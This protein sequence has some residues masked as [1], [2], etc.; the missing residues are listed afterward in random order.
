MPVG[1]QSVQ[2]ALYIL[3]RLSSLKDGATASELAREIG[4][5]RSTVFR[6]M[7]TLIEKG[8]VRQSVRTKR[9][10]LTMKVFTLGSKLLAQMDIRN[11]ARGVL[12]QLQKETGHTIHLGIRDNYEVVYIDKIMGSGPIQ[13][14][15]SIGKRAPLYC[16]GLGKAILAFFKERELEDYIQTVKFKKYTPN[17]ITDPKD[18]LIELENIRNKGY[19][20]D[21][22]EHENGIRCV[23]APIFDHNDE[24]IGSISVAAISVFLGNKDI[25]E[26]APLV[27]SA[28]KTISK[29]IGAD[30]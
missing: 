5:N 2:R 8:F 9:Y 20:L 6:L 21:L 22:E 1:I 12:E 19:A 13:M 7:E 4:V 28:S 27:F 14:Y 11:Q 16:T 24:V 25:E 10:Y 23:G 18:L 3:E 15:S 29:N 26:Y 17:T 30:Y